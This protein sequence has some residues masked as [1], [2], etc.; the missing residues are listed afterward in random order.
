MR[1]SDF[2]REKILFK[3][4][5]FTTL[6]DTFLTK[7]LCVLA[8]LREKK[9]KKTKLCVFATLRDKFLTKKLCVFAREKAIKKR[10]KLYPQNSNIVKE[11]FIFTINIQMMKKLFNRLINSIRSGKYIFN[12]L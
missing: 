2:T 10:L 11:I 3:K 8:S 1:L 4:Q 9:Y 12:R 7:K 5:N 6:Q